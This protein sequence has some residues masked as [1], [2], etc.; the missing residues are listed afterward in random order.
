MAGANP[1]SSRPATRWSITSSGALQR[2]YDQG[3]TWQLVDVNA[4]PAP[5]NATNATSAQIAGNASLTASKD[6]GEALK[7]N[8]ASPTFRAVAANGADVWAGGSSGILFHSLDA[9]DH[10]TR[11]LPASTG[12]SLTGDIVSLEF[13]DTL[14]GKVATSTAETWITT[15]AGQ[16]WEKQ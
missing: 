15:D 10:W 16:T 2:S 3:A 14:H 6:A 4:N 7:R 8:V 9:G 5:L 13:V 11:V 12:A 1:A